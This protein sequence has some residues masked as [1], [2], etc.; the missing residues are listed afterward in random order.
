MTKEF[1]ASGR[2]KRT[3]VTARITEATPETSTIIMINRKDIKLHFDCKRDIFN[4]MIPIKASGIDLSKYN[5]N[6]F[7]KGGGKSSSSDASKL[8]IAKAIAQMGEEE[9]NTMQEFELLRADCRK[10]E[11][12]KYG[13]IGPRAKG[14]TRKR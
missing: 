1:C 13:M 7:S 6:L 10:K 3:S 5:I 12:K 14:S 2:R 4:V 11:R 8:A 9:K